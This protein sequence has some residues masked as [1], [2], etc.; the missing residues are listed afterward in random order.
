QRVDVVRNALHV[1]VR[2]R[3]RQDPLGAVPSG[4]PGRAQRSL[5]RI[6]R[7]RARHARPLRIPGAMI[8]A[9][10][11]TRRF[12]RRTV[13]DNVTLDVRRGEI[14]ALLGPN[15]AGK[16][17]TMRMLAGLISATSGTVVIDGVQLTRATGDALRARIGL[18]TESP[19]L[20]DRLT[21]RENLRVYAR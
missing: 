4:R 9:S 6:E 7:A 5:L 21:V 13:V 3:R 19:G 15:G 17:T 10:A 2:P 16:T 20:W 14:V 1:R 11:L 8:A 12:D 18:L